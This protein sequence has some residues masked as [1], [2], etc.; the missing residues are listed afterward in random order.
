[1]QAFSFVAPLDGT[2]NFVH[3]HPHYCVSIGLIYEGKPVGGVVY[4][5][6]YKERFTGQVGKGAFLNDKQIR[7]SSTKKLSRSLI[8]SGFP[9]E[10]KMQLPDVLS[11]IQR[12]LLSS[13]GFRRG[14]SAA[15]DMCY[16]ACG[17]LDAYWEGSIHH[18]D[19][20]AGVVIVNQAGGRVS[21]YDGSEYQLLASDNHHIVTSNGQIH[22]PLLDTLFP[23][24]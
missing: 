8:A 21:R 5:P 24:D 1:M 15:L 13:Q 18:W 10:R 6:V 23:V 16:V 3:G 12:V 4:A 20:A 11:K 22:K 2:T 17:R 19:V 7:V 14:G 9:Y